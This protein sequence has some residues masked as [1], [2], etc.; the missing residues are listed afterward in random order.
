MKK[1]AVLVVSNLPKESVSK[2]VDLFD[3]ANKVYPVFE[4]VSSSDMYIMIIVSTMDAY[5][6]NELSCVTASRDMG[7]FSKIINL[8]KYG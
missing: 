2:C 8:L 1:N 7:L 3:D 4:P 6:L 5:Q